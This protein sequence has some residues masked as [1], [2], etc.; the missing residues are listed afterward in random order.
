MLPALEN[1]HRLTT[2]STWLEA[3][4]ADLSAMRG[5]RFL[6]EIAGMYRPR[7]RRVVRSVSETGHSQFVVAEVRA[8]V[9]ASVTGSATGWR[10]GRAGSARPSPALHVMA[11]HDELVDLVISSGD[12]A[13]ADVG[14]LRPSAV[15]PT[16]A[17][18]RSLPGLVTGAGH[19]RAVGLRHQR[20]AGRTV[21]EQFSRLVTLVA[22]T[23]LNCTPGSRVMVLRHGSAALTSVRRGALRVGVDDGDQIQ[24]RFVAVHGVGDGRARRPPD[25]RGGYA[26]AGPGLLGRNRRRYVAEGWASLW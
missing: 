3:L 25:R 8:A 17:A 20:R 13:A 21:I 10:C 2:P 22:V 4:V 23:E 18:C 6:P 1:Y 26:A 5:R 9:T 12:A 15:A 14:V 19:H 11:D 24:Q 7:S 16:P